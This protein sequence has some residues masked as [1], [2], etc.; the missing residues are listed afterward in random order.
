MKSNK[1]FVLFFVLI[2][3][4]CLSQVYAII[5]IDI[6]IEPEFF[7]GDTIQFNYTID[8]DF[9]QTID[10]MEVVDCPT[11][12]HA[13]LNPK[14]A[15][16]NLGVNVKGRYNYLKVTEDIWPQECIA[17]VV[18][19][20]PVKKVVS[21]PFTIVTTSSFDFDVIL[22]KKVFVK[23]EEIILD[24]YSEVEN[25]ILKTFL[26]Y[27]DGTKDEINLPYSFKAEK[28]GTYSLNVSASKEG[29]K[30]VYSGKQFRVIN[31]NVD[32]DYA[33]LATEG[34]VVKDNSGFIKSSLNGDSLNKII[35]YMICILGGLIILIIL[36]EGIKKIV[37]KKRQKGYLNGQSNQ[38]ESISQSN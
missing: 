17:S 27:P 15:F 23:G 30:E 1:F 28:I 6:Y 10:Y 31:K 19:F 38:K 33:N 20:E 37:L 32:I 16:V 5:D 14:S 35:L 24:Y 4:A 12:P 29:Y 13:M 25:P 7:T 36:F 11:A 2:F 8:S 26:I 34:F 9:G 22:D 21:K 3:L 18:V